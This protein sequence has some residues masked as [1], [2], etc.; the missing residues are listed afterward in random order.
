[1]CDSI[2]VR[3]E[4]ASDSE[5]RR[6]KDIGTYEPV[7]YCSYE[8]AEAILVDDFAPYWEKAEAK[9]C[10]EWTDHWADMKPYLKFTGEWYE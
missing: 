3:K 7:T 2:V 9:A 6:T 1:M 10:I 8:Q 4:N 5:G